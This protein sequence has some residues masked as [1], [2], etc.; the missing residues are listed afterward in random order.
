M[1]GNTGE[2]V[3]SKLRQKANQL[4]MLKQAQGVDPHQGVTKT[5]LGQIVGSG[6]GLALNLANKAGVATKIVGQTAPVQQGIAVFNAGNDSLNQLAQKLK[7][8]PAA[9]HL[10]EK[11]EY[12]LQHKDETAKTAALFSLMQNPSY[13][14]MLKEEGFGEAQ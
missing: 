14:E 8:N 2:E 10:G 1:G 9:A 11:L 7:A 12:A 13:R 6:E 5:V 4:S 3:F